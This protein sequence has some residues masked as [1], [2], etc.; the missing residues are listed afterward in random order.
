MEEKPL[1][2][3]STKEDKSEKS[4]PLMTP[5]TMVAVAYENSKIAGITYI[6]DNSDEGGQ[7]EN[8]ENIIKLINLKDLV[9]DNLTVENGE[10]KAIGNS[11]LDYTVV[12]PKGFPKSE[13]KHLII[14]KSKYNRFKLSDYTGCNISEINEQDL[15]SEITSKNIRLVNGEIKDNQIVPKGQPEFKSFKGMYEEAEELR[16]N[17]PKIKMKLARASY[18]ISRRLNKD[19]SKSKSK[20]KI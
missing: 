12:D 20:S 15:I 11:F 1:S 13:V 17:T 14:G 8:K 18:L 7:T 5:A 9:F 16:Q 3:R 2:T 19:G 10:L 4:E 6:T